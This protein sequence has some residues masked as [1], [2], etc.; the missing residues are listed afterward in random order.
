MPR[1]AANLSLLYR[2][3]AFLDRFA[4]AA[5][6]GF[7]AV[8][9]LFPDDVAP[10]LIGAEGMRLA[11]RMQ[12]GGYL[13]SKRIL[14]AEDAG[15]DDDDGEKNEKESRDRREHVERL[16]PA[17]PRRRAWVFRGEAH[18]RSIRGSTR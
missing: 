15:C 10:E 16:R 14:G 11:R 12:P 8:E 18:T 13:E 6:D 5:A 9:C 4:A 3:H 17:K 2:E 7:D 1:F